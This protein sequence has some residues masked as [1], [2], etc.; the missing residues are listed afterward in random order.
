MISSTI[1]GYFD[2][3]DDFFF[4]VIFVLTLLFI[5]I[6]LLDKIRTR[7]KKIIY[8]FI[9]YPV[10]IIIMERMGTI[11]EE[12][13]ESFEIVQKMKAGIIKPA[14]IY[15]SIDEFAADIGKK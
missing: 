14:K 15:D 2:F 13:R 10:I 4:D 9:T 7:I 8:P 1:G 6:I 12:M 5:K 3:D 11:D